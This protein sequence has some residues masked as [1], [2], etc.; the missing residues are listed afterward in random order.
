M[1][2]VCGQVEGRKLRVNCDDDLCQ[3]NIRGVSVEA[4]EWASFSDPLI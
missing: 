3:K 1:L 4:A 2:C